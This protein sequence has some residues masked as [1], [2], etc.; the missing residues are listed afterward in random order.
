MVNFEREDRVTVDSPCR[1]LGVDF[2]IGSG[3]N[4]LVYIKEVTVYKF[5]KV[6]AVLIGLV[7]A[8]LQCKS[9]SGVNFG[10]TDN[11]LEMPLYSVYPAFEVKI[12]LYAFYRIGILYRGIYIVSLMVIENSLV[13]YRPA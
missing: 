9:L 13:E 6:G 4:F 12:I 2:C 11:I 3:N 10:V 5:H 1:A 7:D 8:T